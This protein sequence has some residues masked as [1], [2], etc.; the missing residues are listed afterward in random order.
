MIDESLY[1]YLQICIIQYLKANKSTHEEVI[2]SLD[3]LG[4]R[5]GYNLCE[6][7]SPDTARFTDD[8]NVM[9]YLCKD[10]WSAM[11]NKQIDNLRTNNSGIFVLQDNNFRLLTQMSNDEES[12][13]TSQSVAAFTCGLLRGTLANFGY[14]NIVTADIQSI[15]C[16]K[17]QINIISNR[18]NINS[19]ASNTSTMPQTA[20]TANK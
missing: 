2:S 7:L 15:P 14:S 19:N 18:M 12:L 4:Y 6:R 20:A 8:I 1:E 5:V 13:E 3:S 10:Y 16:C 17:F 9:K 11:F